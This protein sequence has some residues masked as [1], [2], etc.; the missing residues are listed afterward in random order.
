VV[1]L[2]YLSTWSQHPQ[3]QLRALQKT[4]PRPAA[5]TLE[6]SLARFVLPRSPRR[7]ETYQLDAADPGVLR[8]YHQFHLSGREKYSL[9]IDSLVDDLPIEPPWARIVVN[10]LPDRFGGRPLRG[11]LRYVAVCATVALALQAYRAQKRLW[12]SD[13]QA[14]AASAA[15]G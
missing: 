15:G 6:C 10:R 4:G 2:V 13:I 9:A 5:L 8:A 7:L 3:S 14:E 1:P 12:K 11:A